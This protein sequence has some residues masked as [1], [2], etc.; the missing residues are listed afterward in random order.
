M[1]GANGGF[2]SNS[3]DFALLEKQL[4]NYISSDCKKYI[5]IIGPKTHTVDIEVREN[6]FGDNCLNLY[7]YFRD[8]EALTT[9]GVE[10]TETDISDIEA[11]NIPSSLMLDDSIHLNAKGYELLANKVYEK[12]NELGYIP[13]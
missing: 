11:G 9:D 6:A 10:L 1:V 2:G 12:L 7:R 3:K 13:E 8:A 4:V 5:V